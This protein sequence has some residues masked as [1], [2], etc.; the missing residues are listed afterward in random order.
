MSN[1]AST[2]VSII[3]K[4]CAIVTDNPNTMQ[5]M[6]DLFISK[7]EN[8]HIIELRCFA[9]AINL[10]AGVVVKHVYAKNIISKVTTITSFS[11]HSHAFKAKLKE[12]AKRL[13]IK[14]ETLIESLLLGAPTK[15]INIMNSRSFF[16]DVENLYKLMKPLAYVMSIIQSSS[17]TLA[18]CFLILSYLRLTTNQFIANTETRTFG[19]FVSK[20]VDIRLKEFHNDL[21]L[22]AYYL[23]LNHDAGLLAD[24]RSAVYRYLAEYSKKTGNNLA[25]TKHV[26]GALQRYEIKNGPYALHYTEVMPER[27]FSI[28]DWHHSKRRNRL[29]LFTLE[30]IAKIHTFYKAE[31]S[32]PDD[33]MDMG[34]LEDILDLMD[35]S[36][37][38]PVVI[39]EGNKSAVDAIDFFLCINDNHR[40]LREKCD[41]ENINEDQPVDDEHISKFDHVLNTDSRDFQ[42][43]LIDLGFIDNTHLLPTEDDE[44]T[45]AELIETVSNEDCDI[46]KLL[47]ETMNI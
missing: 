8:Q 17:V 34:Y 38:D 35:D 39:D 2:N 41:E 32:N 7:L 46:D 19:R 40:V 28:L 27:L 6:Q 45:E 13:K 44:G 4:L 3:S 36:S 47:T 14:K 31:L 30:A 10:I 24:G 21:Y 22:S 42:Q 25:T 20:V 11:N 16:T 5:K 12:E 15:I 23:H 1:K 18:D 43:I 26:L 29:N 33:M 37:A 9:H